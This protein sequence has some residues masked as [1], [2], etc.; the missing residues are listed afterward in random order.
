MKFDV[1]EFLSVVKM[2]KTDCMFNEAKK[3]KCIYKKLI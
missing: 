1:N 2:Q 3:R